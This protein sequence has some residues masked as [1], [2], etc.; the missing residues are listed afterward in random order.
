MLNCTN[1]SIHHTYFRW[2]FG[3]VPAALFSLSLAST[4]P[5]RPTQPPTLAGQEMITDQGA[6]AS[7]NA[8]GMR[9]TY[10]LNGISSHGLNDLSRKMSTLPRFLHE[11][12]PKSFA[13]LPQLFSF[14]GKLSW[15]FALTGYDTKH[16]T[17]AQNPDVGQR[18]QTKVDS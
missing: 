1:S 5:P 7:G 3:L 10:S 6:V 2:R 11:G 16:T 17:Y 13:S 12:Q 4:Q 14:T 9:H 8:P 15:C 18:R